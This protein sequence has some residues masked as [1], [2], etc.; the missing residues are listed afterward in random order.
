ML[1][2]GNVS[3]MAAAPALLERA[4][5]MRYLLGDKGYDAD[6]AAI[7]TRNRHNSGHPRAAK[8]Q[9]QNPL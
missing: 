8:P 2:Q 4:S 7:A 3:D 9:A 1:T 5:G 6:P